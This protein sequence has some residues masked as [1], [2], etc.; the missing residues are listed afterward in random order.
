[1]WEPIL[2]IIF[3]FVAIALLVLLFRHERR[4]SG[5]SSDAGGSFLGVEMILEVIILLTAIIP[6]AEATMQAVVIV[7]EMVAGAGI[8]FVLK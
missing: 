6:M 7:A 3:A 5:S 1:M 8:D 4:K 2:E